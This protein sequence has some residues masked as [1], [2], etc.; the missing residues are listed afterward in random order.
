MAA[1]PGELVSR[2]D[3]LL[4]REHRPVTSRFGWGAIVA[5]GG[6]AC[7]SP[8]VTTQEAP[9]GPMG[10]D[11]GSH[12]IVIEI[13]GDGMAKATQSVGEDPAALALSLN[14]R[15]RRKD[16]VT[17]MKSAAAAIPTMTEEELSA[18]GINMPV[19]LGIREA[20][21]LIRADRSTELK[22]V[23]RIMSMCAD[24]EVVMPYVEVEMDGTVYPTPLPFDSG[25]AGGGGL[26][27]VFDVRIDV[28]GPNGEVTYRITSA[29][30]QDPLS[31]PVEIEEGM[32]EEP[33]VKEP[34]P[35]VAHSFEELER[36]LL[37]EIQAGSQL[38]AT[39]DGRKGVRF[40]TVA[41]VLKTLMAAGVKS[42]TFK[43]SYE[44]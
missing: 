42:V 18:R 15:E 37:V 25:I 3:H 5:L 36:A 29:I 17:W 16:L 7:C 6:F 14:D 39:I 22:H 20:P 10:A 34:E 11:G 1:A 44:Q 41:G 33:V 38:S 24:R 8:S 2:V 21:L 40:G 12:P 30:G 13:E 4:N 43:G 19:S 28:T 23:L 9:S 32:E 35:R 27:Q 31:P 26:H